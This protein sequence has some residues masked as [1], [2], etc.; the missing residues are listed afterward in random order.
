MNLVWPSA[1]FDAALLDRALCCIGSLTFDLASFFSVSTGEVRG[2]S[3]RFDLRGMIC[4]YGRHYLA[5]WWSESCGAWVML[6]DHRVRPIGRWES[7]IP[8]CKKGHL[9]PTLLIYEQR[10]R[11][12]PGHRQEPQKG[13]RSQDCVVPE[14]MA[15]QISVE[16]GAYPAPPAVT[17]RGSASSHTGGGSGEGDDDG[18]NNAFPG[19][20]S[21]LQHVYDVE[22]KPVNGSLGIQLKRSKTGSL[23]V[24]G[25]TVDN[26]ELSTQ[27]ALMDELI[28]AN[29]LRLRGMKKN[30]VIQVL[31]QM[32]SSRSP[33]DSPTL[34]LRFRSLP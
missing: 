26:P 27:I 14:I 2:G 8:Y 12:D 11:Q 33:L 25:F 15:A 17:T 6:D 24:V 34:T 19:P 4:Y 23:V 10:P 22:L 13:P 7:V 32:A 3:S 16:A 1:C 30:D 29:G 21:E 31:R 28:A 9:Q 5:M 20:E 18:G